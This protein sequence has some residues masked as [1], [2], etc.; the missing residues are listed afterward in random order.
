MVYHPKGEGI[1][2]I[3]K[4]VSIVPKKKGCHKPSSHEGDIYKYDFVGAVGL[5][6]NSAGRA[7][8][9]YHMYWTGFGP[10]DMTWEPESHLFAGDL[11][12]LWS[13]Y[14][15]VNTAG[16]IYAKPGGNE[17]QVQ[18]DLFDDGDFELRDTDHVKSPTSV[19]NTDISQKT[20]PKQISIA[21]SGI[22]SASKELESSAGYKEGRPERDAGNL[23]E[24]RSS[25]D[26]VASQTTTIISLEPDQLDMD[27][28]R[29]TYQR[30]SLNTPDL[31][32]TNGNTLSDPL[33]ETIRSPNGDP[34]INVV[35]SC[36]TEPHDEIVPNKLKRKR[37]FCKR[38]KTGCLS[39]RD[40]KKKCD[41]QRPSCES[42]RICMHST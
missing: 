28:L 31:S 37:R 35:D 21:C 9:V 27:F 42:C 13:K 22:P 20:D 25:C 6:R 38:S 14:G 32:E 40:R 5:Q 7:I 33:S 36:S 39:C 41:G 11:E 26:Q 24:R 3:Q 10:K 29:E 8:I 17:T 2:V 34:E 16:K 15:R 18:S 30:N 23:H 4:Y 12:A 19:D 1:H